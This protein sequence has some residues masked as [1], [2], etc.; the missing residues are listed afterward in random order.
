[1]FW[2]AYK[3]SVDGAASTLKAAA[4]VR[5]IVETRLVNICRVVAGESHC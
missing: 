2:R 5:R 1:M 3:L 4:V